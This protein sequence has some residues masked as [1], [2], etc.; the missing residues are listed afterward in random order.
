MPSTLDTSY[1]LWSVETLN[2]V[3]SSVLLQ[4]KAIEGVGQSHSVN[5]RQTT[6]ADHDKLVQKLTNIEAALSWKA[7]AAN[8]GNAG[9]A[10]RYSSFSGC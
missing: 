9:Y 5:G 6:L 3:R 4:M 2:A 8:S 7:T 10:S 1:R